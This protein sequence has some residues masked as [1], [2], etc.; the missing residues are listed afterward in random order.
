MKFQE[1]KKALNSGIDRFY[2]INGKDAFLRTKAQQMIEQ[3]AVPTLQDINI[4]RYNDDNY[5]LDLILSDLDAMPMMSENRIVVLKDLNLRSSNDVQLIQKKIEKKS[6]NNILV[7]NDGNGLNWY[8][9]LIK[10]ATVVDCSPLDEFMLQK[11]ALKGFQDN[12]VSIEAGALS[13]LIQYCNSDLNRITNEVNKLS[14]FV[15]KGGKVTKEVVSN[16]VHK[17]L[18]YNIFELSNAV[19][20]KDSEEAL[21]IVSYLLTQKESAQVLLMMLLSNFRRMFFAT[22]SKQ[23]NAEIAQKLGVKEYSIKIAKDLARKFT[24]V[25]LK[26]ILDFGGELDYKIKSGAMTAENA[27]YYFISNITL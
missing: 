26:S 10:F 27:I 5:N 16:T 15:G 13:L 23:T 11:I 25:K 21:Q 19:A 3:K 6:L 14:N 8:K 20:K 4:T 7:I 1:L 12:D 22:I 18:E 2:I 24:P 17:D 9:S